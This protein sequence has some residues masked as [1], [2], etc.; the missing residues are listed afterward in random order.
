VKVVDSSGWLKYFAAG[1]NAS[2]FA[3]A[4][5]HVPELVVPTLSLYEVFKRVAQQRIE[6]DALQVVAAM[7]QGRVVD[8]DSKI[9]LS[10]AHL[11]M[12][13]QLPM[14]D[15]VILETAREHEATIWTPDS[16]LESIVGVEYIKASS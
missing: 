5:E 14:A 9:A 3:T 6:S 8:L 2:F 4:I 15:S 13:F 10:A 11:S 16:H 1:Q 12:A 7:Q